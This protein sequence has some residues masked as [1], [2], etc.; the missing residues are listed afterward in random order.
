MKLICSLVV[1]VLQKF[2]ALQIL[3]CMGLLM[4]AQIPDEFRYDGMV[5]SLIGIDGEGLYTPQ[6]FGLEPYSTCTACWRG[7]MMM[8]DCRDNQLLLVGMEVNSK[9]TPDINGVRPVKGSQFFS[10]SYMDLNLKTQFTGNLLLGRDFINEMYVHMGFQRP[11][12]YREVIEIHVKEGDITQVRDLS[13]EMERQRNED[14]DRGAR[15]ESDVRDWIDDR[16]SL[17]YKSDE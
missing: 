2:K 9:I 17:D 12:A 15:P 1:A 13:E 8:Y 10:T 5:Y 3:E 4:T 7:F 6:D 11:M 14:P 16:F